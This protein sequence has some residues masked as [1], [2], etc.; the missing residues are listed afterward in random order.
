LKNKEKNNNKIEVKRN[1]EFL[2]TPTFGFV[3]FSSMIGEK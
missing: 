3:P 1:E 2:K